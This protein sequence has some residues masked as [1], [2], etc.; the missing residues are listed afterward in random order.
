[1]VLQTTWMNKNSRFMT[2][3]VEQNN[4]LTF[5]QIGAIL[6]SAMNIKIENSK[7][8]KKRKRKNSGG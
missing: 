1:M 3:G 5:L 7:K 6:F 2:Q 4:Q 8:N